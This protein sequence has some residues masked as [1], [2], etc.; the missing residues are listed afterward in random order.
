MIAE[1]SGRKRAAPRRGITSR[2]RAAL[3]RKYVN[4]ARGSRFGVF[5]LGGFLG[6]GIPVKAEDYPT[7]CR[8]DPRPALDDILVE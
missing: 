3:V 8:S 6:G 5:G 4:A 2:I 1:D 7:D